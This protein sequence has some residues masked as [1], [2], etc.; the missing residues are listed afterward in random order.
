MFLLLIFAGWSFS[1]TQDIV[2]PDGKVYLRFY[3]GLER[4]SGGIIT[5][6]GSL[7]A[8]IW[9]RNESLSGTPDSMWFVTHKSWPFP[10]DTGFELLLPLD[11]MIYRYG[12]IVRYTGESVASIV[13][14][15]D[16]TASR[17]K[18]AEPGPEPPS[19]PVACD[20]VKCSPR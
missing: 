10:V 15:A 16:S 19:P 2:K 13:E 4:E 20:W 5:H 12:V 18:I 6:P 17:Y 14:W 1:I 3:H 9:V 7:Y 8:E 11:S